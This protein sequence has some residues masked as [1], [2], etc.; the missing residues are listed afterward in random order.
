MIYLMRHGQ[1]DETFIGGWSDVLLTEEGIRDVHEVSKWIKSNLSISSIVCSD[2]KRAIQTAEI[3]S[4]YLDIDYSSSDM[5]REQSK[6]KLNGMLK[7]EAMVKYPDYFDKVTPD[8]IYPNGESLRDLYNKIK[9][10]LD[11]IMNLEDNTLIIT[12]RGVINMIY[13]ILNEME[14]DMDKKKF[15]VE[16]ASVHELDVNNRLIK[17]IK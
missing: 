3:V 12:H 11:K 5:F 6:G 16:T 15:G 17:R 14:L 7:S 2:V 9:K 4:S 1:D 8:T 13:Y 10:Y